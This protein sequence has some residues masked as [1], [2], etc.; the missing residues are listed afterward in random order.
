[1][2][3]LQTIPEGC[4]LVVLPRQQVARE[5][6]PMYA[7]FR[8]EAR[9]GERRSDSEDAEW[10]SCMPSV[11]FCETVA[12][13]QHKTLENPE[14]VGLKIIKTPNGRRWC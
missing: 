2:Q 8:C 13:W 9:I 1:M 14:G 6:V 11:G 3:T 7:R 5:R 10:N 4:K 12:N